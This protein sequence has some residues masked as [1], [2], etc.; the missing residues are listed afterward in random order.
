MHTADT[1]AALASPPGVSDRA[2]VRCSGSVC[3]E[4]AA[5][6]VRP[7]ISRP[8]VRAASVRV[9]AA[10]C[11]GLVVRA[12]GPASY[13]G[14][15][16]LEL[17]LPGNPHLVAML[18]DGL[19]SISGVRRAA[20]G[21]FTARA[22]LNG[23]LSLDEAEGVAAMIAAG[24]EEELES[25]R[26]LEWGETGRV[27]RE[28]EREIIEL[29]ALVEA[30]IDF[31][32]QEDVVPI[33]PPVL[34]ERVDSLAREML[35]AAG[36]EVPQR[37]GASLPLVALVGAPNAGKSTLFNALLGRRRSVV[38]DRPGATRDAIIESCD[39]A[40][41]AGGRL[42]VRLA[43]LPGLESPASADPGQRSA[44]GLLARAEVLVHCDP[45]GRFE[46]LPWA[47]PANRPT[48]RVRTKAD[49]PG[50]GAGG[51]L[52]VCALDGWKLD[53][54]KRGIADA[55]R[56]AG[57]G[58]VSVALARHAVAIRDAAG[59]LRPLA[60]ALDPHARSLEEPEVIAHALRGALDALESVIGR[61]AP[62]DVIGR[63]FA[64]FC[65]GK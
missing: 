34:R 62:D 22:Y 32:D 4:I 18:L 1:I 39:L 27:Y 6:L 37:S 25:A 60:E 35:S 51:D 7:A 41:V 12:N 38:S 48:L 47:L 10:W 9:G 53:A 42:V 46:A 43:D 63:I 24:N 59:L 44:I 30:G 52:A 28:W 5:E 33:A 15:D 45:E 50:P 64:T 56:A 61:V 55:A 58:S 3:R 26:R 11:P 14:E 2:L 31:T 40:G 65:V 17:I 21:E 23:R 13:T 19:C 57:L 36:A 20:P 54:L 29:L 8:G 16:T 49:L